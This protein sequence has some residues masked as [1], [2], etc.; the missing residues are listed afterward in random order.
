MA[1]VDRGPRGYSH[2]P[3]GAG[4]GIHRMGVVGKVESLWRY[5]VKSMAGEEREALFVGYAGVYGDRLFAIGN[6]ASPEPDFPI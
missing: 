5:P 2:P 6:A 1:R 3:P 4:K